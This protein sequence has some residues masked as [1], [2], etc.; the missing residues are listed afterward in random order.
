MTVVALGWGAESNFETWL[1]SSGLEIV[2]YVLGGLL[3][4][5]FLSWIGNTITDR[6]DLNYKEGDALVRSETT[7]HRHALAQVITWVLITIVY[8]L[9]TIE[10]LQRLGFAVSSLVAPA[11]VLGA[12]LGF[13]AQ[14]VVQD[15]LAGFFIIAE[16][17]YGFGDVVR[18]AIT[19]SGDDAYGTVE[20]VTLRVTR[21]RSS[22]GEVITVPNGQI[23]KAVNL[24]KDWARAVVD[25]P[26]PTTV[27]INHVNDVL[28]EV[29]RDAFADLDLE[30][31]LLDEPSVMGV[32]SLEL[33]TVNIRMVA[34]TLPGKQFQVGRELRVRVAAALRREG[35]F[36]G[37]DLAV[38]SEGGES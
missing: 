22:D 23:V 29:G 9:V 38:D 8:T 26:V 4:G 28:R 14:R 12:A 7:K 24:S 5:R 15:I 30:P 13:G 21:L 19:G 18:I 35:I 25:V 36:V 20:D 10:V 2:L 6:I 1:R 27:D 32:E 11:T 37:P 34:R 33:E 16:R 3:A 17:Q 31:L